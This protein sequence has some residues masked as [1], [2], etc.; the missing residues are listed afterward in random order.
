[1]R[2]RSRAVSIVV[3]APRTFEASGDVGEVRDGDDEDNFTL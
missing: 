1:M 3:L 2:I